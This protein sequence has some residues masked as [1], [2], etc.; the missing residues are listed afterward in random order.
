VQPADLLGLRGFMGRFRG[1]EASASPLSTPHFPR[2]E[3]PVGVT[4][5]FAFKQ[6]ARLMALRLASLRRHFLSDGS[7]NCFR[8][9]YE[10]TFPS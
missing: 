5:G 8:S 3:Y 2:F 6:G 9:I 7:E 10:R 4:W 1:P